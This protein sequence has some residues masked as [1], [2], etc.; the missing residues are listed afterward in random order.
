[1]KFTALSDG[2]KK[3]LFKIAIKANDALENVSDEEEYK[4]M[5]KRSDEW[6]EIVN[7][8]GLTFELRDYYKEKRGGQE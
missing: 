1:M 5:K 7:M 3:R 8:L 6:N 2:A 4:K